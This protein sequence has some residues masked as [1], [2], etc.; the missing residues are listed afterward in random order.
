LIGRPKKYRIVEYLLK[1]TKF[2]PNRKINGY[3]ELTIDELEAIRLAD[4]ENMYQENAARVM[5][6][7]RQTFGRIIKSAHTKIADA[8]INTK[9]LR[10][11]KNEKCRNV[12]LIKCASCGKIWR[13][14]LNYDKHR[15]PE[16]HAKNIEVIEM[17]NG[18]LKR[19]N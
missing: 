3:V 10:I 1:P 13:V 6:V 2:K 19:R 4:V 8:I 11:G 12:K 17:N 16:C 5:D 7:S 18:K 15:C 14:P 9:E